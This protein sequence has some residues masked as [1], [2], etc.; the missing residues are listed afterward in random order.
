MTILHNAIYRFNATPIK[1][2]MA[3]FTETE[4]KISQFILKHK[5]SQIVKAVL[6]KKNGA[7]GINLTDF[8]LYYKATVIKTVWYW[9]KDRNI[10][11]WNKIESPEIDPRTYGH[12]IFD[13]GGKTIQWR[14]DNVFNKGCWENWSTTC[15][16]M[17][18]EHFLTPYTKINSKWVKDL[19]VRP[20]TIK[21]L[22]E[23]IS[24][25]LSDINH[26]RILYEPPPRVMEIKAKI[27]KWDLIKLKS[28]C[29]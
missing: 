18:L 15:K 28:F 2:P 4:Q 13:K 3:F 11:Q 17:K 14:K 21:L 24:K 5:R 9:H 1:L 29:K 12:L 26:S 23:N 22:E 6:R 20:E 19:N 25:T 16:R 10:D 7:G 27:N 8:R